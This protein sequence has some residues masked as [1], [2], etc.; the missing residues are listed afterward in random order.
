MDLSW[1]PSA[2]PQ[3]S[4]TVILVPDVKWANEKGEV[5]PRERVLDVL[6]LMKEKP[7]R[8]TMNHTGLKHQHIT[9]FEETVLAATIT[10][11]GSSLLFG[12]CVDSLAEDLNLL[13][14]GDM[15]AGKVK[16][17]GK[18]P[19]RDEH[20]DVTAPSSSSVFVTGPSVVWRW[21]LGKTTVIIRGA[22]VGRRQP[23]VFVSTNS[24][25][26]NGSP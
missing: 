3:S 20:G 7:L 25:D 15:A 1:H 13:E 22:V 16:G 6:I 19:V 24:A 2:A 4:T 5:D 10:E 21:R 14:P 12:V 17:K 9:G 11:P 23:A 26:T 18:R 8:L